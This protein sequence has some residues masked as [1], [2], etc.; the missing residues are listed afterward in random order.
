MIYAHDMQ[1][2]NLSP[3]T[4]PS[5]GIGEIFAPFRNT[6]PVAPS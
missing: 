1:I 3:A 2:R 4:I 6:P 5:A